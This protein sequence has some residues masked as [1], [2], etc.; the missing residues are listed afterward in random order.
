MAGEKEGKIKGR[1][2]HNVKTTF[3][4]GERKGR[5]GRNVRTTFKKKCINVIKKYCKLRPQSPQ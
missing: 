4:N 1:E 5:E 2:G 3:K